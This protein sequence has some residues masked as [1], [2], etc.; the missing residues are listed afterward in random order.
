MI[1]YSFDCA[2]KNLGICCIE[3]DE[4]WR[5]KIADIINELNNFYNNV[6]SKAVFYEQSKDILTK[7]NNILDNIFIIK[8]LNIIDLVPE[9]KVATKT[10]KDIL[11]RLKYTLYCLDKQLPKPDVVLIEHQMSQN[12]KAR[13]ISRYIESHYSP[14]IDDADGFDDS[15]T[16]AIPAYPLIA[17][18]IPEVE[19][20]QKK[21]VHVLPA[22]LKNSYDIDIKSKLGSYSYYIEKYTNYIA[23]KKHSTYNFKYFMECRGLS[24]QLE[25][26]PNKLDDIA[27]AFMMAYAWSI[28]NKLI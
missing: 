25:N 3:I 26:I 13:G 17:A 10:S 11:R 7:I 9:G 20:K 1:I 15:I 27:D 28:H 18:D 5:E 4:N 2:I 8:F 14:K 19:L 24:K 21:V 16:F 12:D 22:T 6:S 23:N